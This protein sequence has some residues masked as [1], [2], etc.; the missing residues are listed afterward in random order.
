VAAA[1]ALACV[2]AGAGAAGT[3]AKPRA[4]VK[5]RTTQPAP[6][7]LRL[8]QV[9]FLPTDTKIGYLMTGG[10]VADETWAVQDSSGSTVASGQIGASASR[11]SWSTAYPDV[12]PL[13]FS[14]VT[15]PGTYTLSVAG[16]VNATS[17]P[18][19]IED[20]HALYG[21]LVTDGVNFFENQ[22][23]GADVIPGAL[24]RRPSHLN[25]E[26]ATVYATPRF[27]P[28]GSDVIVGTLRPIG[29]PVDVEGGWF[30]AGDYL[31]FTFTAAY[32]D[33]LLYEAARALGSAAPAALTTEAQYGTQWLDKMWQPSTRTLYLQV[34]IGSGNETT[35]YGD[36][37][38]WR[39]PETDDANTVAADRFATTARPVFEAASPGSRIAPDIAGRVAAA[40]ALAAQADA[41]SDRSA[42]TAQLERATSLYALANTHPTGTLGSTL[43]TAYYPESIW[44]DAMELAATEIVLAELDLGAPASTY[45]PYLRQAA[46]WAADYIAHDSGADT[47]NLYDVSALAHAD[48]IAAIHRAGDPPGL[49]VTVADLEAN[50]KAQVTAGAAAAAGSIFRLGGDETAFDVDSHTFGL[51]SIEALYARVTGDQQFAAFASEQRDW[52]LGGNPW[53][54]SFMVGVGHVFP[55]CMQSQIP[56]LAGSLDGRPPIDTGAV[57]NGPNNPSNFTGGLGGL[58]TGM[59]SCENDGGTAFTG[60]DSEFVDDVRAWQTDE[61]ALDMTGSAILAGALQSSLAGGAG[62]HS[63]ASRHARALP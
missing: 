50:L 11:G 55:E 59:R 34:G 3:A 49:A 39:L 5:P 31:K 10:A 37:D 52:L 1:A 27:R 45:G 47:L 30:D 44:H 22:R 57:V 41:G 26:H 58:Q 15:A 54:E 25:D 62:A 2:S 33:S 29:G 20:A 56:N 23:D 6:A 4:V 42:A 12:Y 63:A 19:Q 36:H 7:E 51:I 16:P 48:L 38:L 43:P 60:Q 28:N 35:F 24:D 40:F 32:A 53:G 46:R 18:F 8:D 17:T 14:S 9:G 21:P 13:D 61:P